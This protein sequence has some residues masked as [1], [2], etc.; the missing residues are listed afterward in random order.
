MECLWGV[1]CN[2][3]FYVLKFC[4]TCT[5]GTFVATNNTKVSLQYAILTLAQ[6]GLC[7][8]ICYILKLNYKFVMSIYTINV[9]VNTFICIA[10]TMKCIGEK[11]KSIFIFLIR[12]LIIN[13][14]VVYGI[15][16]LKGEMF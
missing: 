8:G 11:T 12:Y 1:Y 4:T 5:G 10:L 15:R 13:A 2:N 14:L 7:F 9:V 6:Y 16:W 3:W